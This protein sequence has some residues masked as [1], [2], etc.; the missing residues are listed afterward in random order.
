MEEVGYGYRPELF[1]LV[2]GLRVNILRFVCC[3]EN[4]YLCVF[5]GEGE[6]DEWRYN[7]EGIWQ[8]SSSD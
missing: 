7:S 5:E 4:V 3:L 1:K 2:K 8:L 6:G